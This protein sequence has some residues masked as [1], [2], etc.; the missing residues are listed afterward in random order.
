MSKPVKRNVFVTQSG[1]ELLICPVSEV[2][3]TPFL[4]ELKDLKPAAPV[5]MVDGVPVSNEAHPDYI[6]EL[7]THNLKKSTF[8]MAVIMEL[9]LDLDLDEEQQTRVDR[10]RKKLDKMNPG[11][12]ENQ[13]DNFL[14]AKLICPSMD[15]LSRLMGAIQSL[16]NPTAQQVQN[17]LDTFRP[18]VQRSTVNGDQDAPKWNRFPV[19][20]YET[21]SLQSGDLGE[22]ANSQIREIVHRVAG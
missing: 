15:E 6:D 20:Q 5:E 18:D 17:A 4:G 3:L 11:A 13:F 22:S 2:D 10:A 14:Y 19:G 9:G 1:E 7:N 21:D 8:L 12:R 16:N